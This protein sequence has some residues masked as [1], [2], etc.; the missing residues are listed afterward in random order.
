M[1]EAWSYIGRTTK[2]LKNWPEIGSVVCA[3]V[4]RPEYA[5]D[6]AKQIAKWIRAGLAIERVPVAWVR[7]HL[8]S[9]MPYRTE[10]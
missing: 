2:P 9:T 4:D 3:A 8:G 7:E 1:T 10:T 5:K 6:T